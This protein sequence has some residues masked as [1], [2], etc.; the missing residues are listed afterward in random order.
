MGMSMYVNLYF[1]DLSL[2]PRFTS[3]TYPAR[4]SSASPADPEVMTCA[5]GL[6][7]RRH[8]AR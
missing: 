8:R 2:L 5:Q 6:A 4:P 1:H 3:F 7:V